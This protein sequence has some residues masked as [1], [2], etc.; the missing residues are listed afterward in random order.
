M[1]DELIRVV[2]ALPGLIWTA[3]PGSI[4]ES[5]QAR[6]WAEANDGPGATFSFSIAGAVPAA[7]AAAHLMRTS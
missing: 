5:R 1:E 6:L 7:T 4:I 3:L 2:D